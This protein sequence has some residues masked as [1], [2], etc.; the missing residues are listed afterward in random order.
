MRKV[1]EIHS[2]YCIRNLNIAGASDEM[3]KNSMQI[4]VKLNNHRIIV[5]F[6]PILHAITYASKHG[7]LLQ[8]LLQNYE[9]F[10]SQFS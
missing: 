2:I 6:L 4:N 5:P 1:I 7:Q 3:S 8:E 10:E 9:Y